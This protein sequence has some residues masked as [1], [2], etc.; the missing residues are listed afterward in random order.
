MINKADYGF[1]LGEFHIRPRL[2]NEFFSDVPYLQEAEERQW[3]KQMLSL[4][5]KFPI[6]KRSWI[7]TGL[8][9]VFTTDLRADEQA[10]AE[11]MRTGDARQTI[12]ALQLTNYGTYIGYRSIMQFGLRYDRDNFARRGRKSELKT[13]SLVFLSF[14]AGLE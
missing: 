7:E 12:L 11:G 9:Q 5:V 2:K 4:S 14:Y 13:G 8:E 1:D 6:L 3:W 10:L